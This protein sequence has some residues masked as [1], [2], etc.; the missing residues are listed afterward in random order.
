MLSSREKKASKDLKKLNI[1]EW[2]T[3]KLPSKW[4][5]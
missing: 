5:L 4:K 2:K 1:K 3:N